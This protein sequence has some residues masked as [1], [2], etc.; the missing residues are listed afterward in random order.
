LIQTLKDKNEKV[1]GKR[2]IEQILISRNSLWIR[3][4][5]LSNSIEQSLYLGTK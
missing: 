1:V 2:N 3:T 4:H 5:Y